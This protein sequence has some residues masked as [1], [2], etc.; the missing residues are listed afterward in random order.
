[1]AIL[2]FP[3]FGFRALSAR[4]VA[5][6][7]VDGALVGRGDCIPQQPLVRTVFAKVAV[8]ESQRDFAVLQ[9]GN[10]PCCRFTILRVYEFDAGPLR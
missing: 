1:M 4:D 3:Q 5:S 7:G 8:F 6:D 9:S 2:T 10:F